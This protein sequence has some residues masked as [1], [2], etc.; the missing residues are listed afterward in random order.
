MIREGACSIRMRFRVE[1]QGYVSMVQ[2][3]DAVAQ[4]HGQAGVGGGTNASLTLS[5][6]LNLTLTLSSINMLCTEPGVA[7]KTDPTTHPNPEAQW[8][9]RS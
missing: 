3:S 2:R 8:L 5:L 4:M 6:S 9:Q 1:A 7:T